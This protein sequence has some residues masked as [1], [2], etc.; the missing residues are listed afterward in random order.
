MVLL[1]LDMLTLFVPVPLI[2]KKSMNVFISSA[3][4]TICKRASSITLKRLDYE[5]LDNGRC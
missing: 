4:P 5:L 2:T 1:F 3:I